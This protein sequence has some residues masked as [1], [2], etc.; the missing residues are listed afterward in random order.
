[1][2]E[3]QETLTSVYGWS[4]VVAVIFWL[5]FVFGGL[6]TKGVVLWFHGGYSVS[7]KIFNASFPFS[8]PSSDTLLAT[9]TTLHLFAAN[10]QRHQDRF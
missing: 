2:T 7:C 1:M 5:V 3:S 8:L 10:H 6:I 4:S 9:F